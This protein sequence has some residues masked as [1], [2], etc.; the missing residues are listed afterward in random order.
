MN[1]GKMTFGAML[2][3]G[4]AAAILL[5]TVFAATMSFAAM[6]SLTREWH[7]YTGGGGW[8]G[9]PIQTGSCATNTSYF[10][11]GDLQGGFSSEDHLATVDDFRALGN[12]YPCND[13][14]P[15][16]C[17]REGMDAHLNFTN[18]SLLCNGCDRSKQVWT[19]PEPQRGQGTGDPVPTAAEPWVV[20]V[21]CTYKQPPR[22]EKLIIKAN[23]KAVVAAGGYECG[24]GKPDEPGA[25]WNIGGGQK[26]VL[27]YLGIS[28]NS[29]V[30]IGYATNQNLNYGPINCQ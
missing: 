3:L 27:N 10:A 22:G 25:Q 18:F 16:P 23:G 4:S 9:G 28:H 17:D 8:T 19:P 24:P 26:E 12:R 30:T 5:L 29:Q 20:N 14:S 13:K 15:S 7:A 21:R 11:S 1:T 2:V 6:S